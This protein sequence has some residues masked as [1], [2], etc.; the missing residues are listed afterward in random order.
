M[1]TPS[2]IYGFGAVDAGVEIS[3]SRSSCSSSRSSRKWSNVRK[4]GYRG[5]GITV[6]T[7]ITH[8]STSNIGLDRDRVRQKTRKNYPL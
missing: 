8:T 5:P 6:S 1:S 2:W 4:Q 7:P 3:L